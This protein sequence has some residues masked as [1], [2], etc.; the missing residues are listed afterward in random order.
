MIIAYLERHDPKKNMHRY[1]RI[2]ISQTLFGPYALIREWG[3]CRAKFTPTG[4]GHRKE[5]WYENLLD[6]LRAGEVIV[7]IKK[8]KGYVM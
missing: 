4:L 3:R 5:V 6:A 2:S 7:Q 8:L 1:Y